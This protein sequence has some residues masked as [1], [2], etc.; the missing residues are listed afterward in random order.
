MFGIE[1][2]GGEVSLPVFLTPFIWYTFARFHVYISPVVGNTEAALRKW[3]FRYVCLLN[4]A[5]LHLWSLIGFRLDQHA[6]RRGK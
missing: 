6:V 4:A 5:V 1:W 3:V 2:T